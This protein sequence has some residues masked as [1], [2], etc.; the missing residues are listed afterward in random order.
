MP[1]PPRLDNTHPAVSGTMV[2][3]DSTQTYNNAAFNGTSVS[4]LT[5]TVANGVNRVRRP[6]K[7]Y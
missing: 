3:Q 2:L 6:S 1:S 5:G 7:L 4:A